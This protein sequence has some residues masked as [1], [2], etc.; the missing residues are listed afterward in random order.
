MRARAVGGGGAFQLAFRSAANNVREHWLVNVSLAAGA[1][2]PAARAGAG[3]LYP[4]CPMNG[5]ELEEAAGGGGGG[6]F[7][8]V[9]AFMSGDANNVFWSGVGATGAL[10]PPVGTPGGAGS[11]ERYPTAVLSS[12]LGQVMMV[13]NVG[14]MAVSGTAE[15]KWATWYSNGTFAGRAGSLGTSFAGTKATAWV[16]AS[17]AFNV[18]TTAR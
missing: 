2:W 12:I 17:G 15:V 6:P 7:S 3:W 11:N 9:L 4:A 10:S 18:M 1:E 13:W 14:P 8:A 5:P 16:D